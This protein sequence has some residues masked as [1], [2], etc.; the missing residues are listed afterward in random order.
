MPD[1]NYAPLCYVES[2]ELFDRITTSTRL[3]GVELLNKYEEN[4]I[5]NEIEILR[6]FL[7]ERTTS[8]RDSVS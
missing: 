2:R 4:K 5:E 6:N 1:V 8:I 3:Y 7:M